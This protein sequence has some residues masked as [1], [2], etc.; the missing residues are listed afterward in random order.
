MNPIRHVRFIEEAKDIFE[1]LKTHGLAESRLFILADSSTSEHCLPQIQKALPAEGRQAIL[2]LIPDGEDQKSMETLTKLYSNLI[3]YQADRH[4]VLLNLGGGV[5]TDL[6]GMLGSTFK[7]GMKFINLPTTV[8]GQVDAAIGGKTGVNFMGYKNMIGT[9]SQAIETLVY[10]EFLNTLPKREVMSGFAEI[11]KHAIIGSEALWTKIL[12][13]TYLDLPFI[14]SIIPEAIR[15]KEHIVSEDPYEHGVRKALNF[16]HTI[17]HALE[18]YAL[19]AAGKDLT[20]GE[21]VALG[22]IAETYIS[23]KKGLLNKALLEEISTL[24]AANYAQFKIDESEFH[25]LIEIMRQDKK[26]AGKNLN[27]TL[28]DGIGSPV[29]NMNPPMDLV[30]DSLYYLQRFPFKR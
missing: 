11:L 4:S 9:F 17:G 5:I 29:I 12:E 22:M 13:A 30:I 20:H 19:E 10:P 21:A 14:K 26:K 23:H 6:G 25:R 1:I 27:M 18:S 7:R 16:G 8:L 24:I 15:V 3:E 28:I 2:L